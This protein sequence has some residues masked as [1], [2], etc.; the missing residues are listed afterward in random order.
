MPLL[1]TTTAEGALK[2]MVLARAPH[3]LAEQ[4]AAYLQDCIIN[5]P[6]FVS[7]RGA[8]TGTTAITAANLDS[9]RP[10]AVCTVTDPSGVQKIGVVYLKDTGTSYEFWLS[11]FTTGLTF[12]QKHFMV[13]S[14]ASSAVYP[15]RAWMV[16]CTPGIDGS[17]IINIRS[18]YDRITSQAA[19]SPTAA[20][21]TL[22][23]YGGCPTTSQ[24]STPSTATITATQ[25]STTVTGAA[26]EIAKISF[27]GT[28]VNGLGVVATVVSTTQ[29]ELMFPA[30]KAIAA[31]A[32][33]YYVIDNL[34]VARARGR[35]SCTSGVLA[36]ITGYGTKFTEVSD[37]AT[38]TPSGG[39]DI[40]DPT[41]MKLV[42]QLNTNIIPFSS[43]TLAAVPTAVLASMSLKNYLL[44]AAN[45]ISFT[46]YNR[47]IN[48]SS[49]DTPRAT[50][51]SW[52]TTYKGLN[53]SFNGLV[54]TSSG[55]DAGDANTTSR[56][57]VHGPRFPEIMDHSVSDGD[58]G[59]VV[60][61][62]PG[63]PDGIACQGGNNTVI[64][65]K[66]QETFAVHGDDPSNFV[67]D[68]IADDGAL[69]FESVTSYKGN[70]IWMG[71]NGIWMYDGVNE[72]EN[73]IENTLGSRWQTLVDAFDGT[74]VTGDSSNYPLNQARCFVY[75]DYLFVNVTNTGLI[76]TIFTDG[77]SRISNTLQLCIYM[78]TRAV[79][80]LTNFNFQ[81][82]VKIGKN[83]YVLL[84][85]SGSTTH[86][87][88]AVEGLFTQG[89]ATTDVILTANSYDSG[90]LSTSVGPW[91]HMESRKFDG[92]DGLWKK[93]WKQLAIEFNESSTKRMWLET[94]AG[95][96]TAGVRALL[97]FT[98]TGSF[99]A[100]RVK[101]RTRNQYMSFRLYEDIANRPATLI[102]GAWQWGYKFARRGA[103]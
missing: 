9:Q 88:F 18:R 77:T 69:T 50:K 51:G 79:S 48:A 97:P 38:V 41:T 39:W 95:L 12:I 34:P 99:L 76:N 58:W 67:I 25:N 75:K 36:A 44:Y 59:D 2:G 5:Q 83:G 65:C 23:W 93:N 43:D 26:A 89:A 6:G 7:R 49:G 10:A 30:P 85:Q 78:P 60:A 73:I 80:F 40:Y 4:E 13:A 66:A 81:G 27:P 19:V 35:I 15:T 70:P 72:P 98:G 17:I 16:Q 3:E 61:T 52:W 90:V 28:V 31:V 62:R 53:I 101:F 87:W 33:A 55:S 45:N 91:F 47:F 29:V 82:Y 20:H 100:A 96:N 63:D 68:K 94:V 1:Q 14:F 64:L 42:A 37:R 32:T 71:K 102:L 21:R 84:P 57:Y 8:I 11:V 46:W 92:G 86:H 103:V 54:E 24:T 56:M 74:S 22:R